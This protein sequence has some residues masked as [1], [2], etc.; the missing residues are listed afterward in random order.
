MATL[1]DQVS[2]AFTPDIVASAAAMGVG[3]PEIFQVSAATA[4]GGKAVGALAA[5]SAAI[6][7]RV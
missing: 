6:I 3:A 2:A 1:A 4:V 5:P 7:D